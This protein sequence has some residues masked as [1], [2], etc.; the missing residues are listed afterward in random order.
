MK[1]S[2]VS[3]EIFLSEVLSLIRKV[4]LENEID[5]ISTSNLG[6]KTSTL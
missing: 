2:K 1:V 6:K 3:F 5:K 4:K